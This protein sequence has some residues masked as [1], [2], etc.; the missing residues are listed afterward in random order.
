MSVA[1]RQVKMTAADLGSIRN[2]L[3][4]LSKDHTK[5]RPRAFMDATGLGAAK[6]AAD[7]GQLRTHMYREEIA[8]PSKR[9]RKCILNLVQAT[10]LAFELF[11]SDFEETRK[12]VML[13]N[14]ML[15]GM[16]PFEACFAGKGEGLITWLNT[17]LNRLPGSAF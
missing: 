7:L 14:S 4:I 15:F 5:L 12:W 1:A 13:P 11:Q 9:L 2:E 6:L 16:T 3:G 8:I 17:R 10:D